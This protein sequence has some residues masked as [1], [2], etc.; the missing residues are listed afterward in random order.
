MSVYS[1]VISKGWRRGVVS[2]YIQTKE[3]S[4]GYYVGSGYLVEGGVV[5]MVVGSIH[6]V[7]QRWWDD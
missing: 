5:L 2:L 4:G 6:V 3:W 7:R 1:K